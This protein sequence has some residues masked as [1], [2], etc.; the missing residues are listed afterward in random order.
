MKTLITFIAAV[1]TVVTAAAQDYYK[2][3]A[4]F[5]VNDCLTLKCIVFQGSASY[6]ISIVSTNAF[7][8]PT[9]SSIEN[10][11][12]NLKDRSVLKRAIQET[13]TSEELERY[14]DVHLSIAIIHDGTLKPIDVLFTIDNKMPDKTIPPFKFATL[15]QKLLDYVQF[16]T[17]QKLSPNLYYYWNENI[18]VPI[19][20]YL[21]SE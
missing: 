21:K 9:D 11:L 20:Y 17:R 7:N 18:V 1:L 16:E 15:R 19:S 6:T 14:Q 13:F 3:G 5:R 12:V 8:Y 4:L 2:D 10:T